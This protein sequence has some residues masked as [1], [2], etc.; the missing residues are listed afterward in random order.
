MDTTDDLRINHKWNGLL[1]GI[2]CEEDKSINYHKHHLKLNNITEIFKKYSV[3]IEFD[4]LCVDTDWSD[5]YLL[6]KILTIYKPRCI[7]VE[8]NHIF[9]YDEDRVILYEDGSEKNIAR[10]SYGSIYQGASIKSITNLCKD[11][12]LIYVN[13]DKS[14]AFLVRND[15]EEKNKFLNCGNLEK[16]YN[17]LPGAAVNNNMFYINQLFKYKPNSKTYEKI[18]N[19]QKNKENL[20]CKT[21]NSTR[22]LDKIKRPYITSELL[23]NNKKINIIDLIFV[24]ENLDEIKFSN[25]EEKEYYCKNH[26]EYRKIIRLLDNINKEFKK[27]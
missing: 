14:D 12:T 3:P 10:P 6:Y 23:L 24:D 18:L 1:L 5:W 25:I 7:M 2:G 4:F 26:S 19:K 11:Y 27:I 13:S 17:Y 9:N 15:I 22:I 16:I 21:R 20:L 8:I